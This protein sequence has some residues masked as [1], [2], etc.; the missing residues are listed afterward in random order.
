[1]HLAIS[2]VLYKKKLQSDQYEKD[3]G[4]ESLE[5]GESEEKGRR[6]KIKLLSHTMKFQVKMKRKQMKN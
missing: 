3:I 2:P 4:E 1:M 6:K 5:E